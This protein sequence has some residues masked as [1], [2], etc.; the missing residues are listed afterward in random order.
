MIHGQTNVN[1]FECEL[2]IPTISDSLTVNS[3][4]S[5]LSIS[6]D[7]LILTYRIDEFG[8]G[9][10]AMTED[11]REIL[12]SEQFPNLFLQINQ[13][14]ISPDSEGFEKLKVSADITVTIAG[15]SQALVVGDSYVLN[16][17]ASILTLF[18]KQSV[19]M[20]DFG[21]EP[22]TRFWGALRVY[23]Q[24]DIDFEIRMYN[25]AKKEGKP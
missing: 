11:F 17:S 15:V 3:I 25:E 16:E 22:P 6:F 21:I 1:K 19:N 24:L 7:D 10:A 12:K 9:I 8:C 13:V 5:P 2:F 14:D 18:G 20:T 23:D 4:R